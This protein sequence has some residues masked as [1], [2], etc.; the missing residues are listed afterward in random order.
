MNNSYPPPAARLGAYT[1]PRAFVSILFTVALLLAGLAP[2]AAAAPGQRPAKQRRARAASKAG[3]PSTSRHAGAAKRVGETLTEQLQEPVREDE[4]FEADD[5]DKR[6]NWFYAERAYPFGEIPADARR[7]AWEARPRP[8]GSKDGVKVLGQGV[9]TPV[10]PAPSQGAFS[11]W[12]PT[13]GRINAIAVHPTNPNIVL[14]G[15]STG[16]IWRSTDGGTNFAPVSDNQ[17]DLAVGAIAF[18]PSNPSV[19]YAGMGDL[20]NTYVGSGVL[21]SLD[22][23]AT[24]TRVADP[25]PPAQ[26]FFPSQGFITDILV[27]PTNANRVFAAQDLVLNPNGV[28]TSG[29]AFATGAVRVSNDG[30]ASWSMALSGRARSLAF[31][32]SNPSIIYATII[33]PGTGTTTGVWRSVANGAPGTWSQI[34]SSPYGNAS[35]AAGTRDIRVAVTPAA[36]ESIYVYSG[37]RSPTTAISVEVSTD[38]G[39]NWSSRGAGGVT[40]IDTGQ[41]GYNTYL[42]VSPSDPNTIYVGGRDVYKTTTGNQSAPTWTN[43]TK[44]FGPAPNFTYN[45]TTNG[46]NTHPDQQTLTF[47]P[48]DGSTFYIGNDGG[49]SKTTNAGATFTSLNQTLSLSQFVHLSLHPTDASISIGGT[50]DNGTQRRVNGTNVWREFSSGDGGSSVFNAANLGMV[51]TT[52][53]S[54]RVN[55]FTNVTAANATFSGTI[56]D[57]DTF[58]ESLTSPRIAFYPPV[59]GNG[60][61]QRLYVGT[62]KLFVCTDCYDTTKVR[63]GASQPTWTATSPDDLTRGS[64]DVIRA[65]AVARS[66]SNYIYTGSGTGVVRA[67]NDGGATWPITGA[68]IPQRV[69]KSIT[70]DPSNPAVAYLTVSGYGSGHVFKTT[71][72]GANWTDISGNLPNIPVNTL[73]IDPQTPTTL[74]IGTDIGVGRSTV[75]GNTWETYNE[76]M[77]PV[78]VTSLAAQPS[79]LIQAATYGRGVYEINAAPGATVQ[80]ASAAATVGENSGRATLTVTRGGDTSG[81]VSVNVRTV[82]NPAAVPCADT[83]T[84]PGVAFARCDYATTVDTLTFA[85]GETT[86][87]FT[88]PLIDDAHVEPNETVQIELSGPTGGATLGGGG[89]MT[90]T[91][92]S[93]DV[94]GQPNPIVQPDAAGIAFFVRQQYLDFLNREPEPGEPWSGLLAGCGNQFNTDPAS[95]SVNCDRI[96]VSYSIFASPE[97]QIKGAFVFRFHR[98]AFINPAA[99]PADRYLPSYDQMIADMRSVTGSNS[100][101]VYAKKAAFA[102]AFVQRPQFLAAYPASMPNAQF[103]DTL[104]G[105][106]GLA[107]VRTT[108][109]SN[110]D[111][112]TK[113]TLTRDFLV[114]S[115]NGATLTRAQVVR[116]IADS[117]EVFVAERDPAFVAVQYYGYLRRT[118]EP[119]GYGAWLGHLSANPGDYRS[120]VN[121]FMNSKEYRLRFGAQ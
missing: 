31:H 99:A 35:G 83:T 97:F 106:Y 80:F 94:A 115:L 49:V 63:G 1:T 81:A 42:A 111:T 95:P 109:P 53:V 66:N 38:G 46:A 78:V 44:N 20:D 119:G 105:H 100:A 32:P 5:A 45:P 27:D 58:G 120:M 15:S 71:D 112:G 82:D 4:E 88:V 43:I 26:G 93:N 50:Q 67:S 40:N 85:P 19:V 62:W 92:T 77:P 47:A 18:A 52:Y 9:W 29:Y 108:D 36:P 41:F 79:G 72:A 114:N 24:W 65:I 117:D 102:A 110:P 6:H 51:F 90:L 73:L 23:G 56:A 28:P 101:E 17:V 96:G 64:G 70:V 86:K 91:I 118:P 57:S 54:G 55:R 84:L 48:G 89:T 103:V 68:G 37:Q 60:V 87:N 69:V 8:A 75:G 30:G 98:L 74:Y 12:G 11:S 39:Q 2:A 113:G 13:S 33:L 121:G 7:K 76:G 22:A 10:G 14:V 104:L 107:S 21:K 3:K 61:D 25:S 116:A 16:G 59:V 34:Y